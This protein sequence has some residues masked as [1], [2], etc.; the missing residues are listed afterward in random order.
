MEHEAIKMFKMSKTA[1]F[2]IFTCTMSCIV[3][4]MVDGYTL[5]FVTK[6]NII[7]IPQ[8]MIIAMTIARIITLYI[9]SISVYCMC[10]YSSA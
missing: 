7:G 4:I 3:Y 9:I 5:L 8:L 10:T 2:T 1:N 6:V